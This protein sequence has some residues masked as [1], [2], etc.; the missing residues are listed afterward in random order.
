MNDDRSLERA[1]R[2]WLE[3]GPTKAPDRPVEAALLE[4][5]TSPRDRAPQR[6]PGWLPRVLT[7]VRIATAAAAVVVV[8]SVAALA[9]SRPPGVGT[10]IQSPTPTPTSTP[11]RSLPDPSTA[12]SLIVTVPNPEHAVTLR[13]GQSGSNCYVKMIVDGFG[14]DIAD[15][16]ARIAID[17]LE[18]GWLTLGEEW[19]GGD[20]ESLVAAFGA[21]W[22][23]R[24]NPDADVIWIQLTRDGAEIGLELRA[25]HTPSG[26]TVWQ[27]HN[28][29]SQPAS[30]PPDS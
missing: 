11:A 24:A 1:A 17:G 15:L 13:L 5:E 18:E 22:A 26:S 6:T 20:A 28:R 27:T 4:I 21:S 29:V 2:S 3:E 8:I 10:P 25:T 12:T 19:V 14:P 9:G 23:G 7:P 30:C 16:E